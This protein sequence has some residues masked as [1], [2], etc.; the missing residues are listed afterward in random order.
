VQK[1]A[2]TDPNLLFRAFSDETRLRLLNLM[3]GGEVCVCDLV[4]TLRIPQPT[5]SRHLATLR[6]AGLVLV[7]KEGLWCHYS[8]APAEGK[9]HE[10][11][12]ECLECCF[13]EVPEL[14]LDAARMKK[15]RKA[16]GCCD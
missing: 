8:L 2:R 10:K 6:R 5:A 4:D 12:I 9:F 13:D 14:A 1:T 15:V 7:R 11:L 3:R 16:R